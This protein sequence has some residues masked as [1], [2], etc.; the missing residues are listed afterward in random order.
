[1]PQS[2]TP[3]PMTPTIY[4]G[5]EQELDAEVDMDLESEPEV[6]V[7]GREWDEDH[8]DDDSVRGEW[9]ITSLYLDRLEADFFFTTCV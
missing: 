1:M 9:R 5:S 7:E 8:H 3:P 6:Q 4:V 2:T